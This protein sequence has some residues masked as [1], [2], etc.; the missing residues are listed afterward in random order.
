MKKIFLVVN[1]RSGNGKGKKL[2]SKIVASFKKNGVHADYRFIDRFEDIPCLIQEISGEYQYVAACGGDGTL[3]AV[4]NAC[5]PYNFT[6]IFIPLGTINIFAK[7]FKIPMDPVKAAGKIANGKEVNIDLI[8]TGD[9]YALLM[10]SAGLDSYIVDKVMT[11]YKKHGKLLYTIETVKN[12]FV[13]KYPDIKVMIDGKIYQGKFIFAGKSTKYAGFL[14]F[15][16]DARFD[17]G[18]INV[19]IFK[20]AGAWA[21]FFFV[22]KTLLGRHLKSKYVEVL[23]TKELTL[24][25]PPEIISQV[26]GDVYKSLP[27]E[28]KLAPGKMRFLVPC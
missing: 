26:D 3:N 21:H 7:E 27:Y 20:K 9:K 18:W 4:V 6:V 19:C 17:D 5:I 11:T 28:I 12:S 2:I 22:L 23:K 10:V 13:Y 24:L 1:P 14:N 25:G 16:P 8:K 15:T